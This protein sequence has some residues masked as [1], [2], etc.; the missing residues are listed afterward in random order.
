MDNIK[1]GAEVVNFRLQSGYIYENTLKLCAHVS[2]EHIKNYISNYRDAFI[3]RFVRVIFEMSDSS[4]MS[5][6][7]QF[8]TD[9]KRLSNLEREVFEMHKR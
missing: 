5:Q 1:A 4:Q 8:T 7:D 2:E 3:K 9:L 6:N